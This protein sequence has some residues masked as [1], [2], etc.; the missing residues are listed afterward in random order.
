MVANNTLPGSGEHCLNKV[1]YPGAFAKRPSEYRIPNLKV[2]KV[3]FLYG[4]TD[5]MD[6][7]GG[8]IVQRKCQAQPDSSPEVDVYSIRKAGHLLMLEN[9]MEFNAAVI[10]GAGGS[11]E[12]LPPNTPLPV[13]LNAADFVEDQPVVSRQQSALKQSSSTASL[14]DTSA[15]PQVAS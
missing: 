6:P 8:L 2:P 3:T 5:W 15:E 14:S 10:L 1:L 4:E 7:R 11:V 9:W 12:H 13:K